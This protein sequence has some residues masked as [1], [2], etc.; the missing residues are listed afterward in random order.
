MIQN[1]VSDGPR[2][3]SPIAEEAAEPVQVVAEDCCLVLLGRRGRRWPGPGA[4]WSLLFH[5]RGRRPGAG[6]AWHPLP[7]RRELWSSPGPSPGL[8]RRRPR[9]DTMHFIT[10]LRTHRLCLYRFID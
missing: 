9:H 4:G 8:G 5:R 1:P 10:P 6:D 3:A 7:P 2:I